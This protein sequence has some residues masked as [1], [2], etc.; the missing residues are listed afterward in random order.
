MSSISMILPVYNAGSLLERTFQQLRSLSESHIQI[1][2]IDDSSSDDTLERLERFG[3]EQRNVTVVH[4]E[5]NLGPA[6]ARNLG[7]RAATSEYVWFV[8]WDDQWSAD[9]SSALLSTAELHDADMVIC[10]ARWRSSDGLDLS[11]ADGVNRATTSSGTEAFDR[12]LDGSI[13][14]YLWNK[15]IRRPLL[16]SD[17]FPAIRTQED[18]CAVASVL[19][20]CERVAFIPD[21]LYFHVV[22][23]GSMTNSRNPP[24]E[25]FEYSRNVVLDVAASLPQSS[26]HRKLADRFALDTI[27]SIVGTAL[28]LSSAEEGRQRMEEARRQISFHAILTTAGVDPKLAT[29]ASVIKVLGFAY[30]WVRS[31]YVQLRAVLRGARIRSQGA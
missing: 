6:G 10:R 29:K 31:R 18:L 1:I 9:I 30:P 4:S 7:L 19:P 15:L 5:S 2:L 17:P 12:L 23:E 16:G 20:R 14:G 26:R 8:D 28:R 13:R 21:V 27:V 3:R 11:I 22:R 25:N 24:L